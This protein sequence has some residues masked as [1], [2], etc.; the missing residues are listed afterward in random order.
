MI[1]VS[2]FV[3]AAVTAMYVYMKAVSYQPS[4]VSRQYFSSDY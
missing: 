4:A 1:R 2:I 3:V